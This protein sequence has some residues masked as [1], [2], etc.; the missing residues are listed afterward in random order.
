VENPA[1][2]FQ[3][4]CVVEA[5][6]PHGPGFRQP[7]ARCGST[8]RIEEAHQVTKEWKHGRFE[9]VSPAWSATT[10]VGMTLPP[11]SF[12]PR[13]KRGHY[14]QWAGWA[15][16]LVGCPSLRMVDSMARGMALTPNHLG[17]RPPCLGREPPRSRS[18]SFTICGTG[19][20]HLPGAWGSQPCAAPASR[21][22]ARPAKFRSRTK[23]YDFRILGED[24][25]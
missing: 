17:R 19:F 5:P 15:R 21:R 20:G 11:F 24:Q 16:G 25:S 6:S 9:R 4:S 1:S 2:S 18:A 10:Q 12:Q 14:T 23:L 7:A 3:F 8:R 13:R 22:C